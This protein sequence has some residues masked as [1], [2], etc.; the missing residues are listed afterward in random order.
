[1]CLKIPDMFTELIRPLPP[2][3]LLS[4]T[5]EKI[6]TCDF[7]LLDILKDSLYYPSSAF[8]GD[9]IRNLAGYFYSFVY[10]DYGFTEEELNADIATRGFTGYKPIASRRISKSELTPLGWTSS[11]KLNSEDGNPLYGQEWVKPPFCRWFI[12]ERSGSY[13]PQHGPDRFSLLYI[14]GE[15]V[16]TFDALY[17]TNHAYP[18]A[19]AVIQPGDGFGGN[20]TQFW[21][22]KSVLSRLVLGNPAGQPE[23]LL[24]G[25]YGKKLYYMKPCW[26]EYSAHV[27]FFPK[28][29]NGH[30]GN[31][32]VWALGQRPFISSLP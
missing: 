5:N 22:P 18:K 20:W 15:G 7:P 3:W 30:L 26:P 9:P 16:A 21:N 25:G 2:Q 6:M 19:I 29:S 27:G 4:L 12:F 8:D 28:R 23:W 32:G 31:V 1:M 10:V 24:Y 13:D 11:V 14:C 17:C